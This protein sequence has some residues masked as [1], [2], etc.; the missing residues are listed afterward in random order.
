MCC[1]KLEADMPGKKKFTFEIE[2]DLQRVFKAHLAR[3]GKKMGPYLCDFIAG[4]V[5]G[6]E[7]PGKKR[8]YKDSVKKLIAEGIHTRQE[9]LDKVSAQFPGIKP[10][11]LASF[12]SD[13]ANPTYKHFD[14]KVIEVPRICL[15]FGNPWEDQLS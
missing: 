14:R 8:P 4:T 5:A 15:A 13:A 12:L 2:E 11:S 7:R 6:L 9:I 3:Q 1:N 10:S